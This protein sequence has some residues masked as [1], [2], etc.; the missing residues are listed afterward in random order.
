EGASRLVLDP[1]HPEFD[2]KA[3]RRLFQIGIVRHDDAVRGVAVEL[4]RLPD[5][6]RGERRASLRRASVC[7]EEIE[8]VPLGPIPGRRAAWRTTTVDANEVAHH[9]IAGDAAAG[10]LNPGAEIA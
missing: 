8:R 2:G 7:A 5:F 9:L 6:A 1:L 4:E 10:Y 3:A